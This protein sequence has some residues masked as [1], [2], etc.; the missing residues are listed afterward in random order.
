MLINTPVENWVKHIKLTND[1]IVELSQGLTSPC[2]GS[3]NPHA[4]ERKIRDPE[5]ILYVLIDFFATLNLRYFFFSFL[6][7]VH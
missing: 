6:F 1:E 4:N 5:I 2:F 3:E 7:S